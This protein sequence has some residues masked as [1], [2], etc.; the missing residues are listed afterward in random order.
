MDYQQ[1]LASNFNMIKFQ[2]IRKTTL[3]DLD[4]Q[5]IFSHQKVSNSDH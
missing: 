1:Y 2:K 5:M 3:E 4:L